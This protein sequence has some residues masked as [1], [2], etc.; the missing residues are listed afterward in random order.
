MIT[1]D[2]QYISIKWGLEPAKDGY[3]NGLMQFPDIKDRIA[4]DWSDANGTDVL[5][6]A[7]FLKAKEFTMSFLCDTFEHYILFLQYMVAHPTVSWYD[8]LLNQTFILEYL[9]C[10]SFNRYIGYNMFVI[11]VREANPSLRLN[12]VT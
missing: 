7:G 11:K 4:N 3:Y 5:Y 10:S 1:V 12:P 6:S 2:S 8:G 9:T